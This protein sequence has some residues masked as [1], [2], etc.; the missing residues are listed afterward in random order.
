MTDNS[1]NALARALMPSAPPGIKLDPTTV[2]A[3][4]DEERKLA[5]LIGEETEKERES[6]RDQGGK[7]SRG[8]LAEY[9]ID[10]VDT[11]HWDE[12]L[13]SPDV[14]SACGKRANLSAVGLL[15]FVLDKCAPSNWRAL[16]WMRA[17][18]EQLHQKTKD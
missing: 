6:R 15:D 10:Y 14:L 8:L 1:T 9:E 2:A 12:F 11:V 13:Q 16:F 17:W 4:T 3:A 7:V 5:A 18:Y